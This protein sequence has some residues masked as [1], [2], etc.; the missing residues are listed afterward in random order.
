MKDPTPLPAPHVRAAHPA[1]TPATLERAAALLRAA[2]DPGRLRVLERL[3]SGEVCVS[4][5]AEDLDEGLTTISNRLKV[6]RAEGLVARRREGKHLHYRL[7]DD[8]VVRL[9]EMAL[10]HADHVDHPHP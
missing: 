10:E 4:G 1:P 8:H 6:L 2:G 7:T 5:L 9:I 3:R